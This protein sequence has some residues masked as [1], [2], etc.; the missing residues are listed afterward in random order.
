M[1]VKEIKPKDTSS[2]NILGKKNVRDIGSVGFEDLVKRVQDK[3]AEKVEKINVEKTESPNTEKTPELKKSY[4][5]KV[6]ME[7]NMNTAQARAMRGGVA[8][9]QDPKNLKLIV[10]PGIANQADPVKIGTLSE[11]A[12]MQAP[13]KTDLSDLLGR[14]FKEIEEKP[15]RA[16]KKWE[17]LSEKAKKREAQF[18]K[19]VRPKDQDENEQCEEDY[20]KQRRNKHVIKMFQ[21]LNKAL[22]QKMDT[23]GAPAEPQ[24]AE[25]D[26]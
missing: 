10:L 26:E 9:Q 24:Q 5:N 6:G 15:K 12:N 1:S 13:F 20:L 18:G 19:K 17:E 3:I 2:E 22:G 4:F 25:D 21:H 16:Q 23:T 8:A 11:K 7:V 14:L